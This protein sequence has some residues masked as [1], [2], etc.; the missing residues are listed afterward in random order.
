MV[1]THPAVIALGQN[2]GHPVT[3]FKPAGKASKKVRPA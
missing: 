3:K 2:K 1:K